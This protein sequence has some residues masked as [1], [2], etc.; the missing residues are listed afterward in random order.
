MSNH[1]A[2]RVR[3]YWN[4]NNNCLLVVGAT[5]PAQLESIRKIVGDIPILIPGIGTQG[6]DLTATV[7]AG[8]DS[9]N[10]GIVI[11][12]SSAIIFASSGDDF[13]EAARR[14]TLE[15]HEGDPTVPEVN[16]EPKS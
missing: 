8:K 11:N 12:S 7:A 3:K 6:G 16:N 9:K 13:A 1:V 15:L 2:Y 10:K 5:F 14:K 4:E